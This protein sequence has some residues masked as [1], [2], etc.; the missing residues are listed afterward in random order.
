MKVTFRTSRTIQGHLA[1][2]KQPPRRTLQEDQAQGPMVILG[3]WVFRMSE[4]PLYVPFGIT[5]KVVHFGQS[6]FHAIS[7]WGDQS[8]RIPDDWVKV[9]NHFPGGGSRLGFQTVE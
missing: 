1:H 3:G 7:G 4:V 5:L 9:P 2:E 6:A 8:T